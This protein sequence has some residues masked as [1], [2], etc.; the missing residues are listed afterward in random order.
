M[1][2]AYKFPL[3][4]RNWVNSA[5]KKL[6]NLANLYFKSSLNKAIYKSILDLIEV[7]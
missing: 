4:S 3:S 5:Q 1:K 2:M 7:T 6:T